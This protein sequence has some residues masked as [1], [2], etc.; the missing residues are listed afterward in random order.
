MPGVHR[1]HRA[2]IYYKNQAS[3]TIRSVIGYI[4]PTLVEYEHEESNVEAMCADH[5][6]EL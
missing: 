1:K 6:L 4:A 3:A 5:V 2:K